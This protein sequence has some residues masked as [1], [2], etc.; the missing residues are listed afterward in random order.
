MNRIFLFATLFILII[1]SGCQS[2]YS[3]RELNIE[4]VKDPQYNGT[5]DKYTKDGKPVSGKIIDYYDNGK[6]IKYTATVINGLID[7]LT[8]MY[9][10]DGSLLRKVLYKNGKELEFVEFHKNTENINYSY[11]KDEKGN[12]TQ[13]INYNG[14]GFLRYFDAEKK[15]DEEYYHNGNIKSKVVFENNLVEG[16]TTVKTKYYI[17]GKIASIE[18]GGINDESALYF[19]DNGDTMAYGKF[20]KGL[21]D[22]EWVVMRKDVEEQY[23]GNYIIPSK[24]KK[25]VYEVNFKDGKLHGVAKYYGSFS[26]VYIDKSQTDYASSRIRKNTFFLFHEELF[27]NN[28]FISGKSYVYDDDIR[29]SIRSDWKNVEDEALAD[30]KYTVNDHNYTRIFNLSLLGLKIKDYLFRYDT[31][32][33]C[34]GDKNCINKFEGNPAEIV[35]SRQIRNVANLIYEQDLKIQ[36]L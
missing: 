9:N 24:D 7:G 35:Y 19:H 18:R 31:L 27:D 26:W 15:I 4:N 23:K 28:V 1:S 2:E 10:N 29:L 11:K 16:K 14:K 36:N 34:A 21:F 25:R 12:Y 17:D 32:P 33:F 13:R 8:E 22:G 3:S 30:L 6:D 5:I 20:K